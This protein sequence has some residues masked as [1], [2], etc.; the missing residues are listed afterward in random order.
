MT[1]VRIGQLWD[2]RVSGPQPAGA[3]IANQTP[4]ENSENKLEVRGGRIRNLCTQV[5][6]T[7]SLTGRGNGGSSY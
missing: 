2:A 7:G 6:Q 4:S 3:G 1:H 5:S